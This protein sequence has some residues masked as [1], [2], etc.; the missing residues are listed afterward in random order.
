V[1]SW[2]NAEANSRNRETGEKEGHLILE[3]GGGGN[4]QFSW[5][6]SSSP[7]F[8]LAGG[9]VPFSVLRRNPGRLEDFVAQIKGLIPIIEPV[10]GEV[11]NMV[12]PGWDLP[13]DLQKRLPDI[14]WASIYGPPYISFFGRNKLLNAPFERIEDL[15]HG[16]LWLQASRSVNDPVPEDMKARIRG[17]L[18]ED[19]FMSGKRWR[20]TDGQAPRFEFGHVVLR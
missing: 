18:G 7:S 4:Y 17:Y 13:F 19:A 11:R 8:S 2:L 10:Y 16:Y 14:P 6:K 9:E 15:G 3:C 12:F 20:Y 1:D 5:R